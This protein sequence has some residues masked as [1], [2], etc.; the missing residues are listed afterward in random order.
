MIITK[1]STTG[2][3]TW[4]HVIK[5]EAKKILPKTKHNHYYKETKT[6]HILDILTKMET[7]IEF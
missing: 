7:I 4:K 6:N 3:E 5:N 2:L 1:L